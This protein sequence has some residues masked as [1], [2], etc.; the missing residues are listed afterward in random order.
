MPFVY[1]E[2]ER[3]SESAPIVLHWVGPGWYGPIQREGS[4]VH[5]YFICNSTSDES[6]AIAEARLAGLGTPHRMISPDDYLGWSI[7]WIDPGI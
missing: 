5:E 7:G 4:I 1:L 2:S 3:E 6:C